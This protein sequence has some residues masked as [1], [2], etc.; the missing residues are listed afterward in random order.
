MMKRAALVMAGILF[1]FGMSACKPTE[2]SPVAESHVHRTAPDG[3]LENQTTVDG[4]EEK[5]NMVVEDADPAVTVSVFT[6]KPDGSGLKQNMDS[7]DME[8]LD[9]QALLDLMAD[10]EVIEPDIEV[11]DFDVTDGVITMNLSSL[12]KTDDI[13]ILGAIANTFIQNYEAKNLILKIDGAEVGNME[14]IKNYKELT[15]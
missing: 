11:L 2:K 8:E 7:L 10:Y 14:F 15:K 13:Q 5:L 1:A 6:V 12:E 9:A 3:Y 4:R